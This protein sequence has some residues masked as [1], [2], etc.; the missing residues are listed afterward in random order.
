MS[1]NNNNHENIINNIKEI[2]S[3][4]YSNTRKTMFNKGD[5]KK[6]CAELVSQNSILS[7][8][9]SETIHII[10]DTNQIFIDYPTFKTFATPSNF[11]QI[12]DALVSK[13]LF[14]L[15]THGTFEIHL[16]LNTLTVSGIERYKS[17]FQLYYNTCCSIGL[18]YD[19]NTI[20]KLVVH[21]TPMIINT[22]IP[23]IVKF[24]DQ[25]IKSKIICN[26]KI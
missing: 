8:L 18:S 26:Q 5:L 22:L 9:I 25:S 13:I 6:K 10:N 17:I 24:T 14:I 11:Q 3:N 21:N 4:Y 12:I 2:Q 7:E 1:N 23:I 19:V 20:D 16:N 15:N